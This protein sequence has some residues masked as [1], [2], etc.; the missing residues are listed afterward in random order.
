ILKDNWSLIFCDVVLDGI[1]GYQILQ[2]FL[3]NQSTGRFVLMSG[4]GSAAGALDATA[5]GAYDYLLKPFSVEDILRISDAVRQQNSQ[6][7]PAKNFP[8]D[9][10]PAY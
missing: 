2:K 10:T 9:A 3:E 1:D 4:Y 8:A 7:D 5:F 6:P